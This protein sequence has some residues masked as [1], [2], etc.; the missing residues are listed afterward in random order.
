[1]KN[2]KLESVHLQAA[3]IGFSS[4][5]FGLLIDLIQNK[6]GW[7]AV[8]LSLALCMYVGLLVTVAVYL[9]IRHASIGRLSN[10]LDV[11]LERSRAGPPIW[12]FHHDEV[13]AIEKALSKGKVIILSPDLKND[14][15]DARYVSTVL[16]NLRQ[17]ISYHYIV[18][19]TVRQIATRMAEIREIFSQWKH[20]LTITEIGFEEFES[21][22]NYHVAVFAESAK[23][24]Q[25]Y[26]ELPAGNGKWWIKLDK[27]DA[28]H[29]IGRLVALVPGV[30]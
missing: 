28:D 1:M 9:F 16:D 30:L 5:V 15:G 27:P 24:I 26:M 19:K 13:D 2:G 14:S 12:L 23:D 3:V 21:L 10:K 18:P 22:T 17:Q 6:G 11:A 20:L 7:Q 8:G 25:V 4:L 29:F